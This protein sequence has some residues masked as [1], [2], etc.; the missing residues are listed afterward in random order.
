MRVGVEETDSAPEVGGAS[1]TENEEADGA[2]EPRGE[3]NTESSGTTE[4]DFFCFA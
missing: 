4:D 1:E 3:V 2:L